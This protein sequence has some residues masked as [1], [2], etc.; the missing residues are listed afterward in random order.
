MVL[1][2]KVGMVVGCYQLLL[3]LT[4]SWPVG[5]QHAGRVGGGDRQLLLMLLLLWLMMMIGGVGGVDDN[6]ADYLLAIAGLDHL[7]NN[8]LLL[9]GRCNHRGWRWWLLVRLDEQHL[10]A[11]AGLLNEDGLLL[12]LQHDAATTAAALRLDKDT[13]DRRRLA[14]AAGGHWTTVGRRLEVKAG[15]RLDDLGRLGLAGSRHHQRLAAAAAGDKHRLAAAADQHLLAAADAAATARR[16]NLNDLAI[17]Q[18]LDAV[19]YITTAAAVGD[20]TAVSETVG[21]DALQGRLLSRQI[22]HGLVWAALTAAPTAVAVKLGVV[23][24]VGDNHLLLD[25]IDLLLVQQLVHLAKGWVL[26]KDAVQRRDPVLQNLF[27]QRETEI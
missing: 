11:A 5:D 20:D 1:L 9:L 4:G 2:L 22:L 6:L 23:Y 7:L 19:G 25:A 13:A 10:L 17:R 27:L 15:G 21:D 12:R 3:L 8:L 14:A 16:S 26:G 18:D 24:V